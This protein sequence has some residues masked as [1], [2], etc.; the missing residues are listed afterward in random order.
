MRGRRFWL[1]RHARYHV[2]FKVAIVRG[3]GLFYFIFFACQQVVVVPL[4]DEDANR[5][6]TNNTIK[7]L[8]HLPFFFIC[9]RAGPAC[10]ILFA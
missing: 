7:A 2:Q 8:V 4:S 10:L 1:E 9:P 3:G 5:Q 6:R